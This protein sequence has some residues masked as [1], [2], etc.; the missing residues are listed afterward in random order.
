MSLEQQLGQIDARLRQILGGLIVDPYL[1]KVLQRQKDPYWYRVQFLPL[2]ASATAIA[3]FTVESGSD[4][5]C[6]GANAVVTDTSD[7]VI[8]SVANTFDVFNPPFLVTIRH[9]GPGQNLM[10]ASV[11]FGNIFGNRQFGPMFWPIPKVFPA[12]AVV[13][14][15]LENLVA[16]D[17]RIRIAYIGFKAYMSKI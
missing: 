1:T 14:T 17:R 13:Q 6:L 3:E 7:A 15:T 16:T 8:A 4:F 5:V 9:T 2:L 11:A 10:N 12:R